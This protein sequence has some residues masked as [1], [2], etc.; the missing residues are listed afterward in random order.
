M[1]GDFWIGFLAGAIVMAASVVV[2][3]NSG[4]RAP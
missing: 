3:F 2:G 4:G 1:S